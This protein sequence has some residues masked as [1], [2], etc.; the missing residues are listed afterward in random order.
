MFNQQETVVAYGAIR[1]QC[2]GEHCHAQEDGIDSLKAVRRAGWKQI[3][4]VDGTL[5]P[6]PHRWCTHW[7]TCPQC[8]DR[9][10]ADDI[11]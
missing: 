7:G 1:L 8:I 2:R 4:K 11:D 6:Y 5:L 3:V 9:G 10:D